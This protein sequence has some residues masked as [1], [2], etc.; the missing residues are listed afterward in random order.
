MLDAL[1]G[2]DWLALATTRRT[3]QRVVNLRDR[4]VHRNFRRAVPHPGNARQNPRR[5]LAQ[6][7]RN[8][9]RRRNR[10]A[11]VTPVSGFAGRGVGTYPLLSSR[12]RP[13]TWR[14]RVVL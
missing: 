9:A 2:R 5:T 4:P 6:R 11:G 12:G 8:T 1:A 14:C 7:R 3:G 13:F 10:V